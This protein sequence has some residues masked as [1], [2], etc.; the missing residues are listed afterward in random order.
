L[1]RTYDREGRLVPLVEE[2]ADPLDERERRL[3]AQEQQLSERER[4]VAALEAEL[5]RLRGAGPA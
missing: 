2:L 4:R 3:T 1:L 5:R